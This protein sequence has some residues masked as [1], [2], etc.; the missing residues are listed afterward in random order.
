M[1]FSECFAGEYKVSEEDP[2]RCEKCHESCTECKGFGPLNCTV[3]PPNTEL[4]LDESRCVSCCKSHGPEETGDC[5]DCSEIRGECI[6]LT[7]LNLPDENKGKT[8]ALVVASSI[9]L[10]LTTGAIIFIWRRLRAKPKPLNQGGYEKL[11]DNAKTLT[12]FKSNH[13]QS[14]SYPEDQVIEYKDR[15]DDDDDDDDIVYMG[16]DGTVYRKFKYGLL[17]DDSE[18]E[19]EYD[20]ESYSFR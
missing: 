7:S 12:S 11:A 1:C 14:T 8:A 15:D 19:L 20:D 4:Y 13:Y 17:E 5:C 18:D 9:L 6:L 2:Q 3:C 10:I 16:Q